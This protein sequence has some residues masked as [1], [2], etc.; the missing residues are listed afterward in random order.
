MMSFKAVMLNLNEDSMKVRLQS[1]STPCP[2]LW[3]RLA[4]LSDYYSI[5]IEDQTISSQG[6]SPHEAPFSNLH[7]IAYQALTESR[8]SVC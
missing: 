2:T 7:N 3:A 4:P 1:L 5:Q 8:S 6:M